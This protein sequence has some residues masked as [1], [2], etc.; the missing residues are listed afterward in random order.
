MVVVQAVFY[1]AERIATDPCTNIDV[2]YM[3]PSGSFSET[4]TG[5]SKPKP[6]VVYTE[7]IS[8]EHPDNSFVDDMPMGETNCVCEDS[9]NNAS[10][11]NNSENQRRS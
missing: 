7:S 3:S 4:R 2:V 6:R 9:Q 5:E 8:L 10:P 11:E 1:V